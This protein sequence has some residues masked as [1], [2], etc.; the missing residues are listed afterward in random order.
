MTPAALVASAVRLPAA[1]ITGAVV[2][3]TVTANV[4]GAAGFPAPSAAVHVTVVAAIGNIEPDAG[5]HV[6]VTR[7][8]ML[9]VAA[10]FV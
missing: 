4:A 3:R 9:S 2:S 6:T 8:L 7:P 10:G 5:K 1:A